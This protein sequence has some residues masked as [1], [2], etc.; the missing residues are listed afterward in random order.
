MSLDAN[1]DKFKSDLTAVYGNNQNTPAQCAEGIATSYKE[2]LTK[3]IP[4]QKH[5]S[6]PPKGL[7]PGQ[8]VSGYVTAAPG[9]VLANGLGNIDSVYPGN[10]LGTT[11][12]TL[13]SDLTAV[14]SNNKNSPSECASGVANAAREFLKGAKL[15]TKIIATIPPGVAVPASSGPVAI[16]KYNGTGVGGIDS[17]KPGPG[18]DASIGEFIDDLT[19]VFANNQNT[20]SDCAQGVSDA[21]EKF[22]L[23]AK[24]DTKDEGSAGNGPASVS[25]ESGSGS[26]L[27]PG[28]PVINGGSISGTIS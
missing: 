18:L 20:P 23:T 16:A 9:N 6:T 17:D 14:F 4:T 1:I 24:I 19:K 12:P 5:S 21:I 11:K 25:S 2:W 28:S 22:T 7:Q 15:L 26:T 27:P 13:V 8:P 3:G 10:G